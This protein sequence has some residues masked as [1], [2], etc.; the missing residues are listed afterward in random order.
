[1]NQKSTIYPSSRDEQELILGE[2]EIYKVNG[3]IFLR[4]LMCTGKLSK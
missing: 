4:D 2:N 3:E 1:M